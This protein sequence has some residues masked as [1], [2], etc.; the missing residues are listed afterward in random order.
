MVLVNPT[1]ICCT[2]TI[3]AF[4]S[5]GRNGMTLC[6]DFGPP[7][8]HASAI[9]LS[10]DT[11]CDTLAGVLTG[12]VPVTGFMSGI[13]CTFCCVSM[14]LDGFGTNSTAPRS[15]AKIVVW[16]SRVVSVLT[17][18]TVALILSFCSFS[19]SCSPSIFGILTS[20]ITAS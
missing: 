2:K 17:M 10:P 16:A 11:L 19:K 12:C 3:G 20:K 6:N 9:S 1:G 5:F 18:M 7:V 8:E 15:I 14:I 4:I 13:L